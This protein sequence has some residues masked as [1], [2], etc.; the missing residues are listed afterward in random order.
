MGSRTNSGKNTASVDVCY[1]EAAP[2]AAQSRNRHRIPGMGKTTA[3]VV[4]PFVDGLCSLNHRR[5]VQ[6]LRTISRARFFRPFRALSFSRFSPT[7]YAVGYIFSRCALFP[8]VRTF[9]GALFTAVRYLPLCALSLRRST[10]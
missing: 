8:A 2:S 3:G 10:K 9:R 5:I 6:A 4:R 1:V 7:A